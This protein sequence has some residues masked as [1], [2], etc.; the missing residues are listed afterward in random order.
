MAYRADLLCSSRQTNI[1][2][3]TFFFFFFFLGGGVSNMSGEEIERE[4]KERRKKGAQRVNPRTILHLVFFSVFLL[5]SLRI[6]RSLSG[7]YSATW[8]RRLSSNLHE[9]PV[10]SNYYFPGSLKRSDSLATQVFFFSPITSRYGYK[11]CNTTLA[12]TPHWRDLHP[13]MGYGEIH[14]TSVLFRSSFA[15]EITSHPSNSILF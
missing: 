13:G 3:L 5:L 7:R 12:P 10:D 15:H 6:Y 11:R 8:V 4:Q 2:K 14:F 1:V 9:K